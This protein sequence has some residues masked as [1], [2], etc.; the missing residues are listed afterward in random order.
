MNEALVSDL[1]SM[2]T[3]RDSEKALR[4][5][6]QVDSLLETNKMDIQECASLFKLTASNNA[7]VK[8]R[9]WNLM[10]KVCE[11]DKDFSLMLIASLNKDLADPNP[12]IRSSS[13]TTL[14]SIPGLDQFA[15]PA[16]RS[17]R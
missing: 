8:C 9:V 1:S 14:A 3:I 17:C 12:M 2:E 16:I 15:V 7:K 5:L 10:V 11:Q 6:D 13:L 4:L